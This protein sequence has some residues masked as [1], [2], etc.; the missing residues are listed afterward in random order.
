MVVVVIVI[1][2]FLSAPLLP[3]QFFTI[4][5]LE[6]IFNY[7][8]TATSGTGKWLMPF[9]FLLWAYWFLLTIPALETSFL[10]NFLALPYTPTST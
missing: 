2:G 8:L 9:F 5:E 10:K 4:L 7:N 6:N 1:V 3:N